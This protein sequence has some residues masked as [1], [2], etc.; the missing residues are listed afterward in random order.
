MEF[1]RLVS[2]MELD[3]REETR[4][5]SRFP[6][7]FNSIIIGDL[8]F[9]FRPIFLCGSSIGGNEVMGIFSFLFFVFESI[10][11]LIV[12]EVLM[13][14]SSFSNIDVNHKICKRYQYW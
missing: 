7:S 9:V 2:E 5:R 1:E 12:A 13:L 10:E 11:V 8:E 6:A 3:R 14:F 4:K